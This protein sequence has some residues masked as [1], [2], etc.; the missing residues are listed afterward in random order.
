MWRLALSLL[1]L[2]SG[3]PKDDPADEYQ[4]P[5]LPQYQPGGPSRPAPLP[6]APLPSYQQLGPVIPAGPKLPPVAPDG[7]S[8][9]PR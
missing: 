7:G 2:L 6:I 4:M 3:C 9:T 5:P 1:V 8:P